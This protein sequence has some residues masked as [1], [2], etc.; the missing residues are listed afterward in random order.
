MSKMSQL[1][2]LVTELEEFCKA[3][4]EKGYDACVECWEKP[5]WVEFI[6]DFNVTS[7]EDFVKEYQFIIDHANEIRA[8]AW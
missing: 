6:A 3:N 7:V 2:E 5:E 4:Y 8:T 1:D